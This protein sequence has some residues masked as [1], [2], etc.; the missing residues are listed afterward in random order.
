VTLRCNRCGVVT[1]TAG[2]RGGTNCR[3]TRGCK[4]HLLAV[5]GA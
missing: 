1:I 5:A 2:K 4:G 3:L